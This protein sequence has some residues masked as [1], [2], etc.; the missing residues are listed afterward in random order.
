MVSIAS[1]RQASASIN[2]LVLLVLGLDFSDGIRFPVRQCGSD[3]YKLKYQVELTNSTK[4]PIAS[5]LSF[6]FQY[7]IKSQYWEKMTV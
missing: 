3:S 2:G 6:L 7:R 4:P 5:C 1:I